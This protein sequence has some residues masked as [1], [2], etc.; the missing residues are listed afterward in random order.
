MLVLCGWVGSIC[1][2]LCGCECHLVPREVNG[3]VGGVSPCH[4]GAEGGGIGV[5]ITIIKQNRIMKS[6]HKM[7]EKM[8]RHANSVETQR[9]KALSIII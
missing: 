8:K 7:W 9:V 3:F 6:L 2:L 5:S 4:R 1:N